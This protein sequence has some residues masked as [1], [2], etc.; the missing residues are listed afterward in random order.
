MDKRSR[1]KCVIRTFAGQSP[2]RNPVKFSVQR[3][4]EFVRCGR[5]SGAQSFQQLW[6]GGTHGKNLITIIKLF[7]NQN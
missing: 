3:W 5:V 7:D 1:L 4:C 2:G 6:N